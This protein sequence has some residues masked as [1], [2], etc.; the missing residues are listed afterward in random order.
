MKWT[1]EQKRAIENR[2]G[3]MLVS[4]SAGSGKTSVMI[5]RLINLIIEG[6]DVDQVLCLT[7]TKAA[8]EGMRAKLKKELKNALLRKEYED[9]K[10]RIY[11]QL[12]KLA[13]ATITTIDAF[14]SKVVRKYFESCSIPVDAEL[15]TPDEGKALR[16]AS[17]VKVLELY[18]EREDEEYSE[19][20]GFLGKKRSEG[21]VLEFLLSFYEFLSSLPDGE[22]YLNSATQQIE[23]GVEDSLLIKECEFRLKNALRELETLSFACLNKYQSKYSSEYRLHV[24]YLQDALREGLESFSKA[25]KDAFPKKPAKNSK[26]YKVLPEGCSEDEEI[27]SQKGKIFLERYGKFSLEQLR[28]D[29]LELRPYI[30]KLC[31][32]VKRFCEEYTATLR[33]KNLTDFSEIEHECLKCLMNEKT[34]GEIR[35]RYPYLLVD[36][37]QDTNRLQ[38]EILSRAGGDKSYF[39]V[40]DVK[41]SIY[42]FRHAEPEIFLEHGKKEGVEEVTLKDNFRQ[43]GEIIDFVNSVFLSVMTKPLTGVDYQKEA[44]IEGLGIPRRDKTPVTV[45][46][47]PKKERVEKELVQGVYSVRA[48]GAEKEEESSLEGRFLYDEIKKLVGIE[49]IYDAKIEGEDKVRPI[50]YSDIVVLYRSRGDGIQEIKEYLKARNIPIGERVEEDLPRS[51]EFL[52]HLLR[53]IKDRDNGESLAITLL[54]PMFDFSESELSEY[55]RAGGRK[56]SLYDALYKEKD[57]SEKLQDFFEKIEKYAKR[58]EYEDVYGLLN[59]IVTD[60]A[61]DKKIARGKNGAWEHKL[62]NAYIDSLSD[63]PVARSVVGYLNHFDSYPTFKTGYETGGEDCVRFMTMHNAKGLEF[64]VVFCVDLTRDFIKKDYSQPVLRHK[65]FGLSMM[66]FNPSTK[67]SRENYYHYAMKDRIREENVVQEMRLLYVALTRARN[68]LYLSGEEPSK[69]EVGRD[70]GDSTNMLE[71]V[72]NAIRRNPSIESKIKV[73]RL[74]SEEENTEKE[75][76]IEIEKKVLDRKIDFVYPHDRATRTPIKYTVTNLTKEEYEGEGVSV[77]VEYAE[78]AE[79]GTLYHKVMQHIDFSVPVRESVDKMVLDEVIGEEDRDRIDCEVLQK[80]LSLSVFD[81]AR[82]GRCRREQA[83]L[84]RIACNELKEGECEDEVLLQ[85]VIDLLIEKDGKY[86][87]VDYKYSGASEEGLIAKYSRQLDLYRTAVERITGSKE[88]EVY[89]LSL[90]N[91]KCIKIN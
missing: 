54:S 14:C 24:L 79:V 52:I 34:A 11:D 3:E 15:V 35:A 75:G 37:F 19:L 7:F 73:V 72:N 83:F 57:G 76:K 89:L 2:S 4:A 25:K 45:C 10:D 74:S 68:L 8:A 23:S 49:T 27:L 63:S 30:S 61:Y 33:K 84:L 9:K 90:K 41:Q 55:K 77:P 86:T 87:V 82:E 64:P 70:V 17:A 59:Y 26:D 60:T 58:A 48:D 6:V 53:V 46:Y 50:R 42:A 39:L 67:I 1:S 40:G 51:A 20:V 22:Q 36:E 5:E 43:D 66:S 78:S 18:G 88:V 32:I 28:V 47:I 80:V 29:I 13:F 21:N 85:G 16:Y 38:D 81:L 56:L 69:S 91:A 12:D 71:F 62:L 31:E 65:K 44:M